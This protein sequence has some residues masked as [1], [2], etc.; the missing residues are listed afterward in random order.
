MN[1]DGRNRG[2]KARLPEF[3]HTCTKAAPKVPV[4]AREQ[5]EHG[6]ARSSK[7]VDSKVG[8]ILGTVLLIVPI[9]FLRMDY[10]RDD[11]YLT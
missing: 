7:R 4:E 5:A 11:A 10:V 8:S 1:Y 2:R 9:R 6:E 3:L